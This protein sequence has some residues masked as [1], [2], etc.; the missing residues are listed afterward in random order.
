MG[1]LMVFGSLLIHHVP[2]GWSQSRQRPSGSLLVSLSSVLIVT[3][4][5][6]YYVVDRGLREWTGKVHWILGLIFPALIVLHIFLGRRANSEK[7]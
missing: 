3:G 4:W 1:F 7:K 2:Q 5:G 6:L